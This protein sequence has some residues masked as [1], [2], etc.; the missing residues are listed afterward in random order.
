LQ[1]SA[2]PNLQGCAFK[3]AEAERIRLVQQKS[4]RS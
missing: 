3:Q 2:I 4:Q 1:G